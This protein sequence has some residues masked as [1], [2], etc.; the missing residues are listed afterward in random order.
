LDSLAYEGGKT[1]GEEDD[2]TEAAPTTIA[3]SLPD[4]VKAANININSDA[5]DDNNCSDTGCSMTSYATS[6]DD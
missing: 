5:I 3:S 1:I 6:V 2:K 4:H